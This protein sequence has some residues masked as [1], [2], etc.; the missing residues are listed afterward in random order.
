[1]ELH[2]NVLNS[3]IKMMQS[4]VQLLGSRQMR[5]AGA[6]FYVYKRFVKAVRR[7]RMGRHVNEDEKGS[8]ADVLR[9]GLV[10]LVEDNKN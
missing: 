5:V 10:R 6:R 1:M 7:R 2:L 9:V 3:S 8:T 4:V